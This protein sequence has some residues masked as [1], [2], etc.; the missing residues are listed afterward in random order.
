MKIYIL[1]S[2]QID[3]IAKKSNSRLQ[4]SKRGNFYLKAIISEY[5]N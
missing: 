3:T 2:E 5:K 1:E 4:F